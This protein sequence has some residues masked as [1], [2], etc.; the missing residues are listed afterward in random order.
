MEEYTFFVASTLSEMRTLGRDVYKVE[1]IN[2][3]YVESF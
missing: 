2:L 1:A 3:K